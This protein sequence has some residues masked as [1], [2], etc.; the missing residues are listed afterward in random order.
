M[1]REAQ[2]AVPILRRHA[3]E[4]VWLASYP[5]SGN[6]WVRF[7]IYN[8]VRGEPIFSRQVQ[9]FIPS[10]HKGVEAAHFT[11][12][13]TIIKSHLRYTETMPLNRCTAGAIYVYRNPL[14]VMASNVGYAMRW[15]SD[16]LPPTERRRQILELTEE[17]IANRGFLGWQQMGMGRWD[18]NVESWIGRALP[19]PVLTVRYEEAR[20]KT[21]EFVDRLCDFLGIVRTADE[22][23]EAIRNSSLDAMSAMEQREIDH[24]WPGLFLGERAAHG[25]DSWRFV[26]KGQSGALTAS[27]PAECLERARAAFAPFLRKYDY[28]HEE[29]T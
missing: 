27:L 5:R 17:F 6:T 23:A 18:E 2:Q 28:A 7:L 14:D 15:A 22:R 24:G 19:F 21:M 16:E 4:I 10:F 8:L 26:G 11:G 13:Y 12:D 25:S 1:T 9:E 3:N 20:C 29:R